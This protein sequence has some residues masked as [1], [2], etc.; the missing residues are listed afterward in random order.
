ME[1]HTLSPQAGGG[2]RAVLTRRRPAW[3]STTVGRGPVATHAPLVAREAELERILYALDTVGLSGGRVVFLEG[4]AGVGK[5]RLAREVLA[6]AR[7]MGTHGYVGRCFDQYTG[8]PVFPFAEL[9]V[10]LLA[11]APPGLQTEAPSRWPEL[12]YVVP[13]HGTSRSV[14][15]QETQMQVFRAAAISRIDGAGVD[16][17]AS[18]GGDGFGTPPDR[19]HRSAHSVVTAGRTRAGSTRRTGA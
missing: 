13:Q 14:N 1:S 7:A 16:S 2:R 5:T 3:D 11:D 8:V 15:S 10:A 6:R 18:G 12:T 19:R 17:G 9:F 4:D